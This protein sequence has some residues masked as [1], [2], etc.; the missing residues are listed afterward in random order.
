MSKELGPLP[1]KS[2]IH[3][4]MPDDHR[5]GRVYGFTEDQMRAYRAEGAAAERERIKALV[6]RL[7]LQPETCDGDGPEVDTARKALACTILA[8]INGYESPAP[9]GLVA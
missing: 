3:T 5:Y 8:A 7:T 9:A 2:I 6:C 4:V 1:P